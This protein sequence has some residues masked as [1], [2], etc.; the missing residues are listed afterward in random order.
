M[1][2]I[3]SV[4]SDTVI[5]SRKTVLFGVCHEVSSQMRIMFFRKNKNIYTCDKISSYFFQN[6]WV[7]DFVLSD[8]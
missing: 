5:S 4:D 6:N 3:S 1:Q 2:E 7:M 8:F